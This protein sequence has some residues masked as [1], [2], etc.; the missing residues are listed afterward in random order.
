MLDKLREFHRRTGASHFASSAS[1]LPILQAIKA[2]MKPMDVCILSKAHA[3]SAYRLVFGEE[4]DEAF[5]S[6]G[7]GLPFAL[8]VAKMRPESTVYV[9]V[10]DGELQEGSCHEALR[11]MPRLGITNVEVH[12]DGNGMQGMGVC[13]QSSGVPIYWHPTRKGDSWECHYANA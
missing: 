2:R 8:G 7:T 13:P 6:L 10:G 12:V 1:V 4:V 3:A 5:W 11:A 9:V